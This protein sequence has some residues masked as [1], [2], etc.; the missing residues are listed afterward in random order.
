MLLTMGVRLDSRLGRAV[1]KMAG[2][3]TVMRVGP[4]VVP[5]V[6]RFLHKVSGGVLQEMAVIGEDFG[7]GQVNFALL[8]DSAI[9][10]SD[11]SKY[12][13]VDAEV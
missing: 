9:T 3:K 13:V 11:E 12:F 6:D 7:A 10:A 1:Q 2:S 8:S 5:H 4:K